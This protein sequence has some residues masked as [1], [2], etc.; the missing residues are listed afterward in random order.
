MDIG[1]PASIRL[2]NDLIREPNDG[3]IVFG[4]RCDRRILLLFQLR[5]AHQFTEDVGNR[6]ADF[7]PGRRTENTLNVRSQAHAVRNGLSRKRPTHIKDFVGIVRIV[8]QHFDSRA[9]ASKRHPMIHAEI[10]ETQVLQQIPVDDHALI[11]VKKRA[12]IEF[13]QRSTDGRFGNAIPIHEKRGRVEPF[14]S[15]FRH[16]DRQFLLP[17]KSL[18][19]ELVIPAKAA[20][21]LCRCGPLIHVTARQCTHS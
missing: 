19:D 2:R 14:T 10:I 8:D 9:L 18:S 3:G 1:C 11:I 13:R 16:T 4:D 12:T 6:I 21:P 20:R 5:F 15:C 17:K 7:A